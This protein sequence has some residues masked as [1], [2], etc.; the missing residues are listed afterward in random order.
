MR[1]DTRPAPRMSSREIG[2][3]GSSAERLVGAFD[4]GL[5]VRADRPRSAQVAT[6]VARVRRETYPGY[7]LKDSVAHCRPTPIQHAETRKG[8]R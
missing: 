6:V 5:A 2:L 4:H 1:L 3:T 7:D 8:S